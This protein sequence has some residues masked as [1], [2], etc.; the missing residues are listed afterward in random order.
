MT[1]LDHAY[2]PHASKKPAPFEIGFSEAKMSSNAHQAIF[3][4]FSVLQAHLV[5][6]FVTETTVNLLMQKTQPQL[7]EFLD[8]ARKHQL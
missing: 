8:R 6:I 7:R 4:A 3:A 1:S 2:L 5:G